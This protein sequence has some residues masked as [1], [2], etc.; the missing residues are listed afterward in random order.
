MDT[1]VLAGQE[2]RSFLEQGND[3]VTSPFLRPLGLRENPATYQGEWQIN[4]F[5]HGLQESHS[6]V[7]WSS[8]LIIAQLQKQTS[9]HPSTHSEIV[10]HQRR[11]GKECLFKNLWGQL[12]LR[13][14]TFDKQICFLLRAPV[15]NTVIVLQW[16]EESR[17][18]LTTQNLLVKSPSF[19]EP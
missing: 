3:I 10:V 12:I 1:S 8:R 7:V 18:A 19:L 2:G 4:E 13:G 6:E 14:S 15:P 9:H 17:C 11:L 5:R 16:G